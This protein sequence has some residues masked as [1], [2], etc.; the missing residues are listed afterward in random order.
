MKIVYNDHTMT[1]VEQGLRH[2]A[3]DEPG[4]AGDKYVHSLSF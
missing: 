4:P 3:P 1:G 2:V